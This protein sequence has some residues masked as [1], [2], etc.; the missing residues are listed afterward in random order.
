M[1]GYLRGIVLPEE[2][3]REENSAPSLIECCFCGR[4]AW[5]LTHNGPD[6]YEFISDF[7]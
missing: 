5:V 3:Q 6:E 1:Q 4:T 2:A 7:K